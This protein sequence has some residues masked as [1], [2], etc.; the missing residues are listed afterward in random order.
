[1]MS[2]AMLHDPRGAYNRSAKFRRNGLSVLEIALLVAASAAISAALIFAALS[3]G[4]PPVDGEFA[5]LL[6]EP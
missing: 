4:I 5:A 1:M 3:W 2:R 6:S